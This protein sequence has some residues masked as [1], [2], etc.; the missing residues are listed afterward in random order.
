MGKGSF[1]VQNAKSNSSKHNSRELAPKYLIDSSAKNYYEQIIEDKKFI[2][3]SKL[4]YKELVKQNMQVKQ[5]PGLIKETVLTIKE[6]QNE[7]DIK[8][9]FQELNKE[10]GGHHLTE[11]SIHRDEGHFLKDEIAYYPTKNILKKENDWFICSDSNIKKPKKDD[12][13]K[14]ININDFEKVF[15]YHAHAKFSMFDMSTGKTARMNKGQMSKRIKFVSHY[16]GLDY[17]P[18]EDRYIKKS[19]NQVKDEHLVKANEKTLELA[20]QKD[21]KLQI[22]KAKE[23]L[24]EEK[25]TRK[26]YA[27]LE[28][29]NR[30]LKKKIS[31]KQIT[32]D[33]MQNEID[34]L[35]E[36]F[37]SNI[38]PYELEKELDIVLDK[39]LEE[40][41]IKVGLFG[42]ETK[43][44]V[45]DKFSFKNA[46]NRVIL[47]GAVYLLKKYEE[48]KNKYEQLQKQYNNLENENV[49][50]KFLIDKLRENYQNKDDIRTDI[51]LKN[52]R[53]KIK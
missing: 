16:L 52:N 27:A 49:H 32:I 24:Q 45:D 46:L 30:N 10:F 22:A 40:K 23:A 33:E 7:D 13:D 25:A 6:N 2:D 53:N 21:L 14:L 39:Y 19:V 20:K 34:T 38:K 31:N 28:E 43:S 17:N 9:L 18:S 5:F 36:Q 26:E 44:I 11:L 47:K 1:S 41:E 42:K 50:L 29:L 8:D 51:F 48:L 15:N 4:K 35:H 3:Q 12:F 37:N